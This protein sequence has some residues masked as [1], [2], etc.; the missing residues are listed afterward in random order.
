MPSFVRVRA[1]LLAGLLLVGCDEQ[2]PEVGPQPEIGE[3]SERFACADLVFVAA[4]PD[5]TQGLFLSIDDG[6]AKQAHAHGELRRE[7]ELED[8][9]VELRWVSGSN[10]Y[11]GHCSRDN[12]EPWEVDAVQEARAGRVVVELEPGG[13]GKLELSIELEGVVLEAIDDWRAGTLELPPLRFDDLELE[14]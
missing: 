5:A 3:L 4:S 11:A 14:R 12:G 9:R 10:V 1:L 2:D 13:E 6:L 8:D 7:Y